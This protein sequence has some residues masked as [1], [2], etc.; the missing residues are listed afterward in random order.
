MQTGQNNFSPP[1][2]SLPQTEQVHLF[3]TFMGLTVLQANYGPASIVTP[4]VNLRYQM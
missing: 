3:A 4:M 2:N 1:E